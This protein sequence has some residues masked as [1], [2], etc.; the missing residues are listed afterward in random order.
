M[1]HVER[2]H[3]KSTRYEQ[4]ESCGHGMNSTMLSNAIPHQNLPY[5]HEVLEPM[6]GLQLG[7]G[8]EVVVV[9]GL[10][11]WQLLVIFV[12]LLLLPLRLLLLHTRTTSCCSQPSQRGKRTLTPNDFIAALFH[13]R[14]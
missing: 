9:K 10:H 1:Q 8:V 7:N 2:N 3:L 4:H 13:E 12:L 11:V 5:L 14:L 6:R